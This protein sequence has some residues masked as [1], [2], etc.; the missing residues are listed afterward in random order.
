MNHHHR[1][2]TPSELFFYLYFYFYLSTRRLVR[3][4]LQPPGCIHPAL[5][6]GRA[7]RSKLRPG[8]PPPFPSLFFRSL[9]VQCAA[10]SF[11]IIH[12]AIRPHFQ[13]TQSLSVPS[14]ANNI[15][16]SLH[17][18]LSLDHLGLGEYFEAFVSHGFDTWDNLTDISEETMA[19]LGV[20]LGHR[21]KLQREIASY[22]GQPRTQ[23]LFSPPAVDG[24]LQDSEEEPNSPHAGQ[25]ELETKTES[26]QLKRRYRHLQRKDPHSPRK[27]SCAY[28]LFG[29]FLRQQPD[30]TPLSFVEISKLVGKRWQR[31]S[32]AERETWTSTAA[33]QKSRYIT[34]L[35]EYQ[36]SKEYQHHQDGLH[37]TKT[38]QEKRAL[39]GEVSPTTSSET[40]SSRPNSKD[41]SITIATSG[42][43]AH[44]VSARERFMVFV[45]RPK[46]EFH[47]RTSLLS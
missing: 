47:A 17:L 43:G 3:F 21:R 42:D 19:E 34:E 12:R 32:P 22:R 30:V 15:I 6:R 38:K 23:A 39:T 31:L 35:A 41:S 7:E 44:S 13:R 46:W 26:T 11:T 16:S 40:V 29:N 8:V 2:L 37:I 28:V 5:N 27:P 45:S 20:R 18:D 14:M 25:D 33:E 36:Q 10:N 24:G 9:T 1:L 4:R